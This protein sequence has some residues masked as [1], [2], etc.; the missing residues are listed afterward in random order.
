[1]RTKLPLA[2]KLSI[3]AFGRI[4]TSRGEALPKHSVF[5]KRVVIDNFTRQRGYKKTAFNLINSF[6]SPKFFSGA[7]HYASVHHANGS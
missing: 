3:A 1:M 2:D 5:H 6:A 7:Q 4:G